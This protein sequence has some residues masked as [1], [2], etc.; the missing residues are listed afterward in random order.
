MSRGSWVVGVRW[1]AR[2]LAILLVGM[3]L[4]FLTGEGVAFGRLTPVEWLGIAGLGMLCVGLLLGWKHEIAGGLLVVA[5]I[6][7]LTGIE[8]A[9]NRQMLRGWVWPLLGL[10]GALYLVSGVLR[11]G[12]AGERSA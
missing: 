7:L 11:R 3:V 10:P 4:A 2:L 12:S 8:L 1:T 9:V 5:A 6:A